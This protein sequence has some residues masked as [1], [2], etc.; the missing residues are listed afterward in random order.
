VLHRDT[1]R[2]QRLIVVIGRRV[3]VELLLTGWSVLVAAVVVVLLLVA[4]AAAVVV[5]HG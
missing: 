4:A 3:K 2:G 5:V 1:R